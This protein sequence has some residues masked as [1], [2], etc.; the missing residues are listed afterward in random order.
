MLVVAQIAGLKPFAEHGFAQVTV[1]PSR[2]RSFPAYLPM[3]SL[4]KVYVRGPITIESAHAVR[5]KL[6]RRASDHLPV[7]VDFAVGTPSA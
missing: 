4:D 3:A 7:V 2:F 5:T 6:T 1:P